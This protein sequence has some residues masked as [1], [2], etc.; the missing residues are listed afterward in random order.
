MP[1]FEGYIAKINRKDG[2]KGNGQ[3]WFKHSFILTDGQTESPWI[4]TEFNSPFP[5]TEG[6]Y[7]KVQANEDAK[8]YL[9]VVKGTAEIV[10]NPPARKG[11]Q[12]QSG[13][14]ASTG[15]AGGTASTQ[16]ETQIQY[17]SSR[18][19]AIEIVFRALDNK[20]LPVTKT[21]SKAGEATR[22]SQ[23]LD[24]IDKLTVRL[25]HDVDTLRLLETVADEGEI[26]DGNELP[27]DTTEITAEEADD[28][29]PE[30]NVR[31]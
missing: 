23:I 3:K 21:E 24:A 14:A 28:V 19:D 6:Q 8:G 12:T 9:T 15:T 25:Y 16:R 27:T 1:Q 31:F 26:T 5:A 29:Q 10:D 17:Q 30:T 4:G 11:A 2:A 7:L 22:F 13:G 18:K 20:A